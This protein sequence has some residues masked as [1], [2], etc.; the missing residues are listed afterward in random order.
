MT[1]YIINQYLTHKQK[2]TKDL[3]HNSS[4]MWKR[5]NRTI[6]YLERDHHEIQSAYPCSVNKISLW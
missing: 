3:T 4:Q 2:V 5:S 6:N 1:N